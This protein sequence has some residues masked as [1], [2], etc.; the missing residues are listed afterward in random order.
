MTE[1]DIK[2]NWKEER[3]AEYAKLTT[4]KDKVTREMESDTEINKLIEHYK[5]M[6][7]AI[8]TQQYPFLT[9][10]EAIEQQQA[11]IKLELIEKW[12]IKEKSFKCD[13]GEATLRTNRSLHI[14]DK[15][16]L[17]EFLISIKKLPEFIK[18]FETA[19]LRKVKDVGMLDDDI[20]TYDEKQNVAIKVT[21]QKTKGNDQERG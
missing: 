19:K 20:A 7:D 13:I 1:D 11:G 4:D 17:I 10:V 14:R 16:K 12:D 15:A 3:I 9:K 5:N 21:A 2:K 8:A 18:S 6:S